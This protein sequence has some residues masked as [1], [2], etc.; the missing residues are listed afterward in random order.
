LATL[1]IDGSSA[2]ISAPLHD[3][4]GAD[5]GVVYYFETSGTTWNEGGRLIPSDGAAGLHDLG[6]GRKAGPAWFDDLHKQG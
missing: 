2:V 6:V 3:E 4:L 5:S 1:S